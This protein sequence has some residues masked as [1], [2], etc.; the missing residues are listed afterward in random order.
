METKPWYKS[1]TILSGIVT[2]IVAAYNSA[3]GQF[4]LPIIPEFIYGILA[5][6]GIYGRTSGTT[7]I[8]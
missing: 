2:V 6:L 7:K 8:G 3:A 4:N 5:A 1:K